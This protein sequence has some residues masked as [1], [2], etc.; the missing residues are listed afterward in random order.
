[1]PLMA[2]STCSHMPW[3][4]ATSAM[5]LVGSNAIELVVP[6]ELHTQNGVSPA[7]TS[8]CTICA[9]TSGRIAQAWS[10]GTMRS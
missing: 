9:S 4:A 10:C 8:V 7:S 1:M 3:L 2:A 5:A 6:R